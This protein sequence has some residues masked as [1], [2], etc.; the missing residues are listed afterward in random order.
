[1]LPQL[2]LKARLLEWM[3]NFGEAKR[4]AVLAHS[5]FLRYYR[6]D[7]EGNHFKLHMD[8]G[9]YTVVCCFPPW[10]LRDG[11]APCMG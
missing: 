1:L 6:A 3:E 2:G 4:C 7:M 9:Q 8:D 5:I 11:G 10:D